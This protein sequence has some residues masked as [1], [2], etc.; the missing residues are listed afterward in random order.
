MWHRQSVHRITGRSNTVMGLAGVVILGKAKVNGE[1]SSTVR[2][3]VLFNCT[4]S[5]LKHFV[6]PHC[7]KTSGTGT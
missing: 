1:L 5:F 7:P 3:I 2:S 4:A 6:G